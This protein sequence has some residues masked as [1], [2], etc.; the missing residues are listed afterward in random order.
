MPFPDR[1]RNY[2]TR[3]QSGRC[4]QEVYN[5]KRGWHI[6]GETEHLEDDH[7]EPEA[8]MLANGRDPNNESHGLIRC[9]KHHRGKGRVNTIEPERYAHFGEEDYSRHPDMYTALE[10]YRSGNREAFAET[11]KRHHRLAERGIRYWNADESVDEHEIER[12]EDMEWRHF[13]ETGEQRPKVKEKREK[14]V[15]KWYEGLF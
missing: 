3:V 12:V 2:H 6:C 4:Q 8:W 7:I 11:S 1:V 10:Q 14:K 5:E 15:K 13:M 9:R